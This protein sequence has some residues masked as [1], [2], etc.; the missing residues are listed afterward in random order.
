MS[1][2][3]DDR[4]TIKNL[5]EQCARAAE[6]T[7]LPLSIERAYGGCVIEIDCDS[8]GCEHIGKRGTCREVR[9][10]LRMFC[11]GW[12]RGLK[13]S[14]RVNALSY[15]ELRKENKEDY[16]SDGIESDGNEDGQYGD[17]R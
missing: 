13:H 7:G 4:V 17:D 15:G 8:G 16:Y 6:M 11:E 14:E 2:S 5:R 12:R 9:E 3:D 1:Y 10:H